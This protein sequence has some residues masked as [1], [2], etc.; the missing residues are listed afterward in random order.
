MKQQ[1]AAHRAWARA[2]GHLP[3]LSP[4]SHS[5]SG[6]TANRSFTGPE[7]AS[8]LTSP[9]PPNVQCQLEALDG[10]GD[11]RAC[12]GPREGVSPDS[13]PPWHPSPGSVEGLTHRDQ[14]S[15]GLQHHVVV[16]SVLCVRSSSPHSSLLK[17]TATS[18][19]VT[20]SCNVT[21]L[22]FQQKGQGVLAGDRREAGGDIPTEL[23]VLGCP[24]FGALPGN[25]D[26]GL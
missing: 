12:P 21:H 24:S 20:G 26:W 6:W 17:S 19:K 3:A 16:Y 7:A 14:V 25:T 2:C 5:P 10:A 1:R 8:V 11:S 23:T 9:T 15:K 22:V 13:E 4:C 18:R